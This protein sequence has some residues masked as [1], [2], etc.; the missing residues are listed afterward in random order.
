M[1]KFQESRMKKISNSV[2]AI[3]FPLEKW[4]YFFLFQS[5][6]Q[7]VSWIVTVL[8]CMVFITYLL[9]LDGDDN[10]PLEG[11][12]LGAAIGATFSLMAVLPA[13]FMVRD[14]GLGMLDEI[15]VRLLRMNYVEEKRFNKIVVYR[16]NL[17]R[18]LRWEEGNIRISEE[19]DIL[20]VSGGYISLWKLRRSLLK[21]YL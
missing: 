11:V 2:T 12:L 13:K 17:P 15:E 5:K 6:A 7:A 10:I 8:G 4:R 9:S 3:F 14:D 19:G 18:L 20:V 1:N 21:E 16:Q